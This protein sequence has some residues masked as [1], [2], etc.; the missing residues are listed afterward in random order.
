MLKIRAMI[1]QDESHTEIELECEIDDPEEA[2]C[3][4]YKVG[5]V[6]V[7]DCA[8]LFYEGVRPIANSYVEWNKPGEFV[9][10]EYL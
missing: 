3:F 1:R 2:Y 5:E 7:F 4:V 10:W 6:H 9:E 8:E